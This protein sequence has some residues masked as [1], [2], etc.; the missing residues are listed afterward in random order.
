MRML[1][2]KT[3]QFL[4]LFFDK[5]IL[6]FKTQ[7]IF[8]NKRSF[9]RQIRKLLDSGLIDRRLMGGYGEYVTTRNGELLVRNLKKYCDNSQETV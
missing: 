5:A 4:L 1:S 7:N 8:K 6:T 9:N 3:Q 2:L